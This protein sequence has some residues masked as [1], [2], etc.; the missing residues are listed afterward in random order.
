M[1][2][3]WLDSDSLMRPK[4]G[5]YRFGLVPQFWKFIEEKAAEG[6]VASSIFVYKEIC[7]AYDDDPLRTWAED[8]PGLPLFREPSEAVQRCLGDIADFVNANYNPEWAAEF[9]SGADPWLIAHARVEG[10]KVVTFESWHGPNARKPKIPN[11]CRAL[12]VT[13]PIDT[14]QMLVELNADFGPG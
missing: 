2:D 3:Y 10:G 9:L 5:P 7:N 13:D 12:G 14:Y 6:V 11:V 4:D 8:R 1:P